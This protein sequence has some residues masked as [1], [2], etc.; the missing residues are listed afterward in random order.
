MGAVK[1]LAYRHALIINLIHAENHRHRVADAL[2]NRFHID[3]MGQGFE[4]ATFLG[5]ACSKMI[6]FQMCIYTTIFHERAQRFSHQLQNL[7]AGFKS[8][9]LVD[10]AESLDVPVHHHIASTMVLIKQ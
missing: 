6:T 7:I 2:E 8:Q 9:Q 4:V 10:D 5:N 1:Q 3:G